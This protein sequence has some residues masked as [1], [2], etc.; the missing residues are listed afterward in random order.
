MHEYEYT[1]VPSEAQSRHV[2]SRLEVDE[3]KDLTTMATV[4]ARMRTKT[5]PGPGRGLRGD[6]GTRYEREF[7]QSGEQRVVNGGKTRNEK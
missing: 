1:Q 3:F 4:L 5:R 6:P 2:E 7:E